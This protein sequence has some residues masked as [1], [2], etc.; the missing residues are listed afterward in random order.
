MV[1]LQK[2]NAQEFQQYLEVAVAEYAKEKALAGNWEE[3]ES[4]QK[5]KEEFSRLLPDGEK[6]ENNYL[7]TI[8]T[9]D[10]E[11]AGILW[12][13]KQSEE[14][15]FIYDIKVDEDFQGKGYGKQAM[16]AIEDQ[17]KEIGFNKIGLHVFGHNK[18]ARSLYEKIGYTTTNVVMEKD[19]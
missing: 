18:I 4:L 14:K 10:G 12:L 16:K 5:A 19:I 6:S 13:A 9:G 2:M 1:T 7:F 15:A 3:N 8:V 17:A 11:R